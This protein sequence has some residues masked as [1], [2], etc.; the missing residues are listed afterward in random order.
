MSTATDARKLLEALLFVSP[1]PVPPEDLARVLDLPVESV[2]E[3]LATLQEVWSTRGVRISRV[4][5]GYQMV[6]CPEAAPYVERLHR[7]PSRS[8]MSRAVM[9][10]LAIIAYRQ[11][12]TKRQIEKI[13]GVNPDYAV[14]TLLDKKLIMEVGRA[15]GPGRPPQFGTTRDFLK[16]FHLNS[17]K[18]LPPIEDF[19]EAH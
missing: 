6:S 10:T 3:E 18:D 19:L 9:E 4:A 13:R 1:R 14:N 17:L 7:V 12:L 2:E 5:G 16:Y 15:P 11:P 8:P